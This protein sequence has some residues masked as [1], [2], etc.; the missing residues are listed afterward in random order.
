VG[1]NLGDGVHFNVQHYNTLPS[2]STSY[3]YSPP[4]VDPY[5]HVQVNNV[6]PD[7]LPHD[8]I[9]GTEGDNQLGGFTFVDPG[10]GPHE[11][12]TFWWDLDGDGVDTGPATDVKGK[13]SD[14]RVAEDV[15]VGRVPDLD[16]PYN[17]DY[18]D[19]ATLHVFD[20]DMDPEPLH[21]EQ[22]GIHDYT[23]LG[24]PSQWST[25]YGTPYSHTFGDDEITTELGFSF[26]FYG[27]EHTQAHVSMDGALSF[28][29]AYLPFWG[30]SLPTGSY[31]DLI[32]VLWDDLNA[33]NPV[34]GGSGSVYHN[35]YGPPGSQVFMVTWL[36]VPAFMNSGTHSAQVMLHESTGEIQMNYLQTGGES[37]GLW[38]T[39]GLNK[40][41]GVHYNLEWSGYGWSTGFSRPQSFK[42][43]PP[44]P[45]KRDFWDT[46]DVEI[47]NDRPEID[48]FDITVD[49]NMKLRVSGNKYHKVSLDVVEDGAVVATS[50]LTRLPGTPVDGIQMS[51]PLL[52]SFHVGRR[53]ELRMRYE[54]EGSAVGSNPAYVLFDWPE[55]DHSG[56]PSWDMESSG[57]GDHDDYWMEHFSINHGGTTQ[58]RGLQMDPDRFFWDHTVDFSAEV[59]DMGSDDLTLTYFTSDPMLPPP[60]I[61]RGPLFFPNADDGPE[62]AAPHFTPFTGGAPHAVTD[63]MQWSYTGPQTMVLVVDDDDGG[64]AAKRLDIR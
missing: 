16:L 53:Y 15:T 35:T 6:D 43:V 7:L 51:D 61:I 11:S 25:D 64:S 58:V 14:T 1:V 24:I 39:I 21:L 49:I 47:R 62:P 26:P 63:R 50:S 42:Y 36:N 45:V 33:A 37:S 40:G 41:D 13:V 22:E 10:T 31:S 8:G 29:S 44:A 20:D 23:R 32:A 9:I 38:P 17:D 4:T 54:A 60:G 48:R 12:W 52:Y 34:Y 27:V 3:L 56:N 57:I 19:T 5:I 18:L 2:S 59:G 55:D 28:S 46:Y 30:T